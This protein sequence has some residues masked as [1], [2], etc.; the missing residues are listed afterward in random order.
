MPSE[1]ASVDI[2]TISGNAPPA[3]KKA[4]ANPRARVTTSDHAGRRF[5]DSVGGR[6]RVTEVSINQKAEEPEKLEGRVVCDLTVEEGSSIA[7]SASYPLIND[8]VDMLNGGGTV[9]G[10]CS[11]YLID[12]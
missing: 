12:M 1:T 11:A 10:G 5:A 7:R 8:D 4:V 9:H 6:L 2:S 3:V